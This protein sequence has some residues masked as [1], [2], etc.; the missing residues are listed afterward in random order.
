MINNVGPKRQ[1]LYL[2]AVWETGNV[3]IFI[4]AENAYLIFLECI[5]ARRS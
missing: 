5:H 2:N 3:Q 4:D 1:R